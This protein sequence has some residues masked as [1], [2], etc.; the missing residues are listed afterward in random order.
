LLTVAGG[1][2]E[3]G[4]GAQAGLISSQLLK[5]NGALAFESAVLA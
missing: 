2:N 5:K 1:L 4:F 3:K